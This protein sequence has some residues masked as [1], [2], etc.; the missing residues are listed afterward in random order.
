V[1]A[2]APERS[3]GGRQNNFPITGA[4]SYGPASQLNFYSSEARTKAAAPK[5]ERAGGLVQNRDSGLRPGKP[6]LS[7]FDLRLRT[8]GAVLPIYDLAAGDPKLQMKSNAKD[9]V[10]KKRPDTTPAS[11]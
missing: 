6:P 1:K 8:H 11:Q 7:I 2:V 9:E 10:K 4:P 3:E 5:R